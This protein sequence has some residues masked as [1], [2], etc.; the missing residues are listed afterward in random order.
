MDILVNQRDRESFKAI[1]VAAE[2][3]KAAAN[4]FVNRCFQDEKGT[5]LPITEVTFIG[6][7]SLKRFGGNSEECI[8]GY[9]PEE[10][11]KAIT[12]GPRKLPSTVKTIHLCACQIG[13]LHFTNPSYIA[14]VAEKL[15]VCEGYKHITVRGVQH[16]D[17][18]HN[19]AEVAQVRHVDSTQT[20]L[21]FDYFLITKADVELRVHQKQVIDGISQ[22]IA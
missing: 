2:A 8:D 3:D 20:K 21:I 15:A 18:D 19:Y 14:Q 16:D 13:L 22:S 6:H 9:T 12:E 7:G 11:F 5:D 10:F 4:K 17:L 1:E